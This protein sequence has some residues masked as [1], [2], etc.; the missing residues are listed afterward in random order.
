MPTNLFGKKLKDRNRRI[1]ENVGTR[2]A[3]ERRIRELS[4]QSLADAAG[5]HYDA[6]A[7]L[8]RAER[9]PN[10]STLE[11]IASALNLP[12]EMLL[13]DPSSVPTRAE[14]TVV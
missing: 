10:L 3:D 11:Q 8:E 12:L 13:R 2:I 4:R 5:V 1:V 6:I 9:V 7:K 14:A